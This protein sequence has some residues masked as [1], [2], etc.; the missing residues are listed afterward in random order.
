MAKAIRNLLVGCA[1]AFGLAAC[2]T[3]SERVGGAAVGAVAGAAIA[4]PVGAVV[5][6]VGGAITGPAVARGVG[7]P[8][9][10]YYWWHGRR[11]YYYRHYPY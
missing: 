6:G 1:A 11:H 9:R 3:P 5:G 4:G 7:I 2:N 10:R 8:H